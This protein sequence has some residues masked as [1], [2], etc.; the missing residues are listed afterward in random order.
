MEFFLLLTNFS[1]RKKSRLSFCSALLP[2]EKEGNLEDGLTRIEVG[3]KE[4]GFFFQ[5]VA[6]GE[7]ENSF[8]RSPGSGEPL[9]SGF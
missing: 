5:P 9:S 3:I 4:L 2:S 7:M 1:Q 8:H 6:F